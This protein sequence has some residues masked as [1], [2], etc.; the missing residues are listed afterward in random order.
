MLSGIG[1]AE[2]LRQHGIAG[3]ASPSRVGKNLQDHVDVLPGLRGDEADH[4]YSEL[5]ADRLAKAVIEGAV[6]GEGVATTFP[7]RPAP[8]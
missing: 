3:R 4:L 5:R 8:S 6:L 7:M 2:E 1:D